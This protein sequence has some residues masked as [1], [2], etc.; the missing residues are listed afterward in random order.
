MGDDAARE[1][2]QPVAGGD[3]RQQPGDVGAVVDQRGSEP[4]GAR[5]RGELVERRADGRR[6]DPARVDEVLE[7]DRRPRSGWSAGTATASSSSQ[8]SAT[9]RPSSG[10]RSGSLTAATPST[11]PTSS[12]PVATAR[13][14]V[15]RSADPHRHRQRGRDQRR[16]V[17][18]GQRR[19]PDP[20]RPRRAARHLRHVGARRVEAQQDRLGVLEQPRAGLGRLDRAA[21]QQRRAEVGLQHADVLGDRRLRVAE[22]ARGARNEPRRTTVT[23][24]RRKR[25]SIRIAYQ[26]AT[27]DRWT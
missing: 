11:N 24:V 6:V 5:D 26:R 23:K 9:V 15:T 18:A 12:S 25:G 20:Q 19:R 7:R 27:E 1:Q 21:R 10:R 13:A 3:Q 16:R 4:F 14:I 17:R 22:L 2:R 8:T